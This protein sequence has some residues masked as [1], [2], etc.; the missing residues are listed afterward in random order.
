M[1]SRILD[2]TILFIY[3]FQPGTRWTP[4]PGFVRD[5]R[6]D[7][8]SLRLYLT[9][10]AHARLHGERYRHNGPP[11]RSTSGLVLDQI[12]AV[13]I[14][15]DLGLLALCGQIEG[16]QGGSAT[17]RSNKLRGK[18]SARA[19]SMAPMAT[20]RPP[21]ALTAGALLSRVDVARLRG[22]LYPEQP[23]PCWTLGARSFDAME[24]LIQALV[25]GGQP[26]FAD[27]RLFTL[28]YAA[29][30]R[31]PAPAVQYALCAVDPPELPSPPGDLVEA[32]L[33]EQGYRRWEAAGLRCG[34]THYSGAFLHA[35]DTP[36]WLHLLLRNHY[37]DLATWVASV[38]ARRRQLVQRLTPDQ[39]LDPAIWRRHLLSWEAERFSEQDQ[40]RQLVRRWLTVIEEDHQDLRLLGGLLHDQDREGA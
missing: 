31:M 32:F 11:A 24:D 17:R 33:K 5:S 20:Q 14:D 39:G 21:A 7:D 35:G 22:P 6:G 8:P 19:L 12:E 28:T 30:S 9:P 27:L 37:L 26:V 36:S 13:R 16:T 25:P 38:A 10:S 18:S 23:R 29:F 3:A 34:F 15:P 4:G 2:H 40:G 1:R